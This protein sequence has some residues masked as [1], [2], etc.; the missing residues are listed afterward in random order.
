[1]IFH[2]ILQRDL[3]CASYL[4]ADGGQA[5]VVDPRWDIDVYLEL[6][7]T[8]GVRIAHVLDT[9]QHADHVSGRE[10]LAERTGA[11]A[12]APADGSLRDCEGA[13]A[14]EHA[15]IAAGDELEV[16]RACERALRG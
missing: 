13:S 3:G 7:A 15:E 12:Y 11:R 8:E 4:L 10:R 1:M 16:A 9:H 5:V 2:Q 6:A 14:P